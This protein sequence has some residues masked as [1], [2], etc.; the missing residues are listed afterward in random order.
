MARF[1]DIEQAEPELAARAQAIFS[2]TQNAVLGTVRRD[3]SPRLSGIDAFFANGE[4]CVGSMPGAR[5]GA[6]LRRD[7]RLALHSI[8]WDSRRVRDGVEDPGDAD[9]KITGTAQLA[10][11]ETGAALRD[12][13]TERGYGP[14]DG[15]ELFTIDIESL[16]VLFPR[17]GQLVVDRWTGAEGRKT[18]RRS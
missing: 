2:A 1:H 9:A 10:D 6:D 14:P 11:A 13:M 17:D 18:I 8:P 4:L 7:A 15:F 16:V 3:G 12:W 5:K